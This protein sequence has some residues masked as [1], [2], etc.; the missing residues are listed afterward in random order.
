MKRFFI[1]KLYFGYTYCTF[2]VFQ[3]LERYDSCYLPKI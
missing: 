3:V 1:Y 2:K